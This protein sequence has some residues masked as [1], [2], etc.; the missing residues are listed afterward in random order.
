MLGSSIVSIVEYIYFQTGRFGTIFLN[1]KVKSITSGAGAVNRNW[2]KSNHEE[3][4]GNET[5]TTITGNKTHPN[6]MYWSE[7]NSNRNQ[8]VEKNQKKLN[9]FE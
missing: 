8:C 2:F 7:F 3:T 1:R 9:F 5:T 4:F 6:N